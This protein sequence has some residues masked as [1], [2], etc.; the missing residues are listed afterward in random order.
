MFRKAHS[1]QGQVYAVIHFIHSHCVGGLCV[2][3][4]KVADSAPVVTDTGSVQ[5]YVAEGDVLQW[6]DIPFAKP[7]VGD[8]RWLAPE[9]RGSASANFTTNGTCNLPSASS[10]VSGVKGDA[11]IGAEAVFTSTSR[12]RRPVLSP[13]RHGL[14]PWGWKYHWA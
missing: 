1:V 14:N 9:P 6:Y 12:H 8:L 7:P 3:S 13:Y 11:A 2:A 4:A 10:G 5:A